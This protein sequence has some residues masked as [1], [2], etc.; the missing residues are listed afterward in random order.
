MPL[1][2]Y[3]A[4]DKK[5]SCAYCRKEFQILQKANDKS[6]SQ[7]PR[8]GAPIQKIFAPFSSGHSKTGLDRRAKDKGF[9]KLKKV[10]KGKYEKLY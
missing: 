7:C 10:D 6:L 1:Y 2:L 5:K 4:K 3:Q 9:H 8:C